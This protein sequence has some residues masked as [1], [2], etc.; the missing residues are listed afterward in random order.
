MGHNRTG[1]LPKTRRWKQVVGLLALPSLDA[2]A[3]ARASALAAEQRLRRLANDPTLVHCFWILTRLATAARQPDF[4][5]ALAEIGIETRLDEPILAFIARVSDQVR[6]EV[7]GHP[8]SGH[9]ATLASLALRRALSETIG[10]HGRSLFGSSVEDL[11]A[12]LRHHAGDVRFGRMAKL[13]FGDFFAATLGSFVERE[14]SNRTG[15]SP[16]L[17]TIRDSQEFAEALDRY[18]RESALIMEEFAGGWYGKHN[19]ES[20]GQIDHQ[21][22]AGFVGYALRKLRMELTR[23]EHA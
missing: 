18:A 21:E 12:A 19:W 17:E 13:F 7:A 15:V 23:S 8:E 16:G 10:Q 11:Q 1:R 4:V 5:H 6:S 20:R 3:V 14:L 9:F 22:T 2:A